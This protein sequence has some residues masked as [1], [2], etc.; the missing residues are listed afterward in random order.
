MPMWGAVSTTPLPLGKSKNL[1]PIDAGVPIGFAFMYVWNGAAI[2]WK[3]GA[4]FVN[5]NSKEPEPIKYLQV[6]MLSLVG[7]I[8]NGIMVTLLFADI[9]AVTPLDRWYG[10]KNICVVFD[11]YP[12]TFVMPT[13]FSFVSMFAVQFAL[14]DVKRILNSPT[15]SPWM[16]QSGR[17]LNIIFVFIVAFFSTCLAIGPSVNMYMH[18][19]PFVLMVIIWPFLFIHHLF[20]AP[21]AER[22]AHKQVGIVL[23]ALLS[24]IKAAA[25]TFALFE[26]HINANV[27]HVIDQ[28]WT[29]TF[30]ISPFWLFLDYYEPPLP[31]D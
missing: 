16:K 27:G 28:A 6:T 8:V 17:V 20:G 5:P 23:L 1:E 30:L 25:T 26:T 22:T 9:P 3:L 10:Y 12:S 4:Y 24:W 21:Q 13:N 15:L 19:A 29:V 11:Y 7:L 2:W 18:T 31:L 14:R